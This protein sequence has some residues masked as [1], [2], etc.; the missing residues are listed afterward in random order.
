MHLYAIGLE[1]AEA[2]EEVVKRARDET[3]VRIAYLRLVVVRVMPLHRESLARSSL[4]IGK[5]GRVEALQA[6]LAAGTADG[7]KHVVLCAVLPSNLQPTRRQPS[8]VKSFY[9]GLSLLRASCCG[10]TNLV[11]GKGLGLAL[12]AVSD[13]DSLVPVCVDARPVHL[14]SKVQVI[15]CWPGSH[16]MSPHQTMMGIA[17][18]AWIPGVLNGEDPLLGM[19]C[20]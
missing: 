2:L 13:D 18:D 9:S 7:L 5:N 20:G 6:G 1:L 10:P 14:R 15:G 8:G 16:S 12:N 4:A 17:N 3:P 19:P 11:I